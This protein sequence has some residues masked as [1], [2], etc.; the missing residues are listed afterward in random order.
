[1]LA[2]G[3]ETER[4]QAHDRSGV[5]GFNWGI[6][7]ASP[8]RVRQAQAGMEHHPALVGHDALADSVV[9]GRIVYHF[10]ATDAWTVLDVPE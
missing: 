8:E 2:S 1:V 4:L 7:P 9:D 3:P 6:D 5:L 10:Y